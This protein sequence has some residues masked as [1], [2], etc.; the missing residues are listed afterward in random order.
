M[1]ERSLNNERTW[2]EMS[3]GKGGSKIKLLGRNNEVKSKHS[4]NIV[5]HNPLSSMARHN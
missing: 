4:N 1:E 5:A 3:V 2:E